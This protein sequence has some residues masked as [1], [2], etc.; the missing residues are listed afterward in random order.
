[1][2]SWIFLLLFFVSS[3]G[4]NP[5]KVAT[6]NVVYYCTPSGFKNNHLPPEITYKDFSNFWRRFWDRVPQQPNSLKQI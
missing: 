1:M 2:V 5:N 3:G 4:C 6:L